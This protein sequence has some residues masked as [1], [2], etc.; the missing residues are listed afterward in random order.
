MDEEIER[1]LAILE[2]DEAADVVDNVGSLRTILRAFQRCRVDLVKAK[3][4]LAASQ[5]T[6]D[7]ALDQWEEWV[8]S[9][10]SGTATYAD[11]KAEIAALRGKEPR[12]A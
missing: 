4:E 7:Y 3:A 10:L 2:G 8:A 12:D 1:L 5:S 6:A 9:E 11:K